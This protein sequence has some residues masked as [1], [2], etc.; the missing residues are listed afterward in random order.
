MEN[1]K[2]ALQTLLEG[3]DGKDIELVDMD[4]KEGSEKLYFVDPILL[5][6]ESIDSLM[7]SDEFIKGMT[8]GAK[9]AG[10]YTAM[11]NAGAEVSFAQDI[12]FNAQMEDIA[13]TSGVINKEIAEVTSKNVMIA[14]EKNQL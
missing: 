2:D 3:V 8:I 10:I 13:K 12:T 5:N 11:I 9:Y 4:N 7:N 6:E 14:N 1:T